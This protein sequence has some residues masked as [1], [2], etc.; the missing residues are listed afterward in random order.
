M[1]ESSLVL[2]SG[3]QHANSRRR[4]LHGVGKE[5]NVR[6]ECDSVDDAKSGIR[7]PFCGMERSID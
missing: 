1:V 5:E 2:R 4:D 6:S 3:R 7:N